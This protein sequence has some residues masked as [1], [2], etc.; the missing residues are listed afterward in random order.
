MRLERILTREYWAIGSINQILWN[1][2]TQPIIK[3]K[4][5]NKFRIT[6]TATWN[7]IASPPT[8]NN[9]P[10]LA[11]GIRNI[12]ENLKTYTNY[13]NTITNQ[14][15]YSIQSNQRTSLEPG[16]SNASTFNSVN[17][18]PFT[19]I[20]D[21]YPT[22]FQTFVTLFPCSLFTSLNIG[23]WY[24]LQGFTFKIEELTHDCPYDYLPKVKQIYQQTFYGK[25]YTQNYQ[26]K[27]Q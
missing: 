9:H 27:R 25:A 14:T 19:V 20:L 3:L 8:P 12:G 18:E 1:F 23:K 22:N 15:Y 21:E 17:I 16:Q 4:S 24:L 6:V 10:Q 5:T 7:N 11:Y 26:I 13:D 2:N